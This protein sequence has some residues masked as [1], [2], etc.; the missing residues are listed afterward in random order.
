M[1]KPF[2]V[3]AQ[4]ARTNPGESGQAQ[5][6]PYSPAKTAQHAQDEGESLFEAAVEN[7]QP[8]G[9][10]ASTTPKDAGQKH[11]EDHPQRPAFPTANPWPEAEAVPKKP[12][13]L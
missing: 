5:R 1:G 8:D 6:K 7:M 4:P 10:V 9:D 2:K 3:G 11:G 13:K 12:F